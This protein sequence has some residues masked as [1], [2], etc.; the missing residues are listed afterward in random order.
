M[1]KGFGI[2]CISA[3]LMTCVVVGIRR[4]DAFFASHISD[5]MKMSVFGLIC[6]FVIALVSYVIGNFV[7]E[8]L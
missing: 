1:L 2:L 3:G 6:L 7:E 5:W 4:A 8:D